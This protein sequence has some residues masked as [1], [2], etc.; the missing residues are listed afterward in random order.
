[1]AGVYDV[2]GNEIATGGG[3]QII[4][5][6]YYEAE[7]ADTIAKV[8]KEITEPVFIAPVFTDSHRFSDGVTQNFKFM[9][10]N[11]AAF[12]KAVKCDCLVN[13]GD[14]VDG[15]KTDEETMIETHEC[16]KDLLGIGLPYFFAQG[17]HDNNIYNSD[18]SGTTGN[19]YTIQQVFMAQY[20]GTRKVTVNISENGT[21]Y[22]VDFDGIDVRLVS[23]NACNVNVATKYGYGN[24]TASWLSGVALDTDKTV[25]LV[26]HLSSIAT[27]VWKNCHGEN[28]D[29]IVSA[30]QNFVS[31]GGTLVQI[32]GHSHVDIAFISPWL[33]VVNA[34][35]KSQQVSGA[36]T[37]AGFDVVSGYI[38]VIGNP[39]RTPET[40]TEDCWTVCVL[41]P[42]SKELSMIRFG[43]GVDRYFHYNPIAPT[44]LST[45]LSGT[46]TWSSSNTSVAT[47]SNG[48][49]TG[50]AS[51][52]CAILAKD[53]AGNYESWTITVS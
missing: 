1:M 7:L 14:T 22:F 18:M 27:Q 31:G 36:S 17:N 30:L 47:V 50:V 43:A 5:E 6:P 4:V 11:I 24:S 45:K 46:I 16:L 34:C 39:S 38:D 41:K 42:Q 26:S 35:Q 37:L 40:A 44:T 12:A 53:T 15:N 32:T 9:N 20:A 13:T 19:K 2:N 48:V 28:A 25:L 52:T 8:Q 51:G 10:A 49:V 21:D 23:L 29:S 3:S 33:S